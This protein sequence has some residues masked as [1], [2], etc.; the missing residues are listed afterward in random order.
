MSDDLQMDDFYRVMG[1]FY[2]STK[3][4]K[5]ESPTR[6]LMDQQ[7][8]AWDSKAVLYKKMKQGEIDMQDYS[9]TYVVDPK[10]TFVV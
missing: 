8:A 3:N 4:Q 10:R 9:I 6:R 1:E 5:H 2:D 7:K